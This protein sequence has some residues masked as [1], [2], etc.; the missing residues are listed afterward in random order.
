MEDYDKIFE[1]MK[2]L[3]IDSKRLKKYTLISDFCAKLTAVGNAAQATLI[4][5]GGAVFA[6][7]DNLVS[8]IK[9]IMDKLKECYNKG[10][11]IIEIIDNN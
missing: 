11:E 5:K 6:Q 1:T 4:E 9:L 2:D 3:G 8:L 7:R 10:A